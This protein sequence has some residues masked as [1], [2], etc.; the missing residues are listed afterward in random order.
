MTPGGKKDF[1]GVVLCLLIFSCDRYAPH[2]H[3]AQNAAII[4]RRPTLDPSIFTLES[5][6]V[7]PPPKPL[8]ILKGNCVSR[9]HRSVGSPAPVTETVYK[10]LGRVHR[11]LRTETSWPMRS[12]RRLSREKA[13]R[14]HEVL[15]T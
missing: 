4:L 9:T 6:E 10:A 15:G 2:L 12:R 11:V 5:F 8:R 14:T 1:T 13:W 7:T 3:A